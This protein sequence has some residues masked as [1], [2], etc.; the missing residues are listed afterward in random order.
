MELVEFSDVG[1]RYLLTYSQSSGTLNPSIPYHTILT[2][3]LSN[4]YFLLDGFFRCHTT[5]VSVH[6]ISR[7]GVFMMGRVGLS[8]TVFNKKLSYR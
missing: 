4:I 3:R 6:I 7:I 2:H 5:R 1:D 8:Q